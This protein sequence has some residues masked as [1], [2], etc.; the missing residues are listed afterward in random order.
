MRQKA[1]RTNH[2]NR[3]SYRISQL[4]RRKTKRSEGD[5]IRKYDFI[6]RKTLEEKKSQWFDEEEWS[7]GM[8]NSSHLFIDGEQTHK[9]GREDKKNAPNSTRDEDEKYSQ[10]SSKLKI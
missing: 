10:K 6:E 1:H 3:N 7:L 9:R 8:R 4:L 5:K 2:G